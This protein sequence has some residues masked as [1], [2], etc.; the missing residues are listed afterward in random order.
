MVRREGREGSVR[1][2][3]LAL[4]SASVNTAK[5]PWVTFLTTGLF[6]VCY[7]MLKTKFS[8]PRRGVELGER[9][10]PRTFHRDRKA[11]PLQRCE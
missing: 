10:S 5:N 4:I 8:S 2:K 1:S 11:G 9:P 3:T 7:L 6:D